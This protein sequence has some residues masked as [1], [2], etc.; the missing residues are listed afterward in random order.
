MEGADD[1]V[2]IRFGSKY[3]QIRDKIIKFPDSKRK[4]SKEVKNN[5]FYSQ[6]IYISKK[7][8]EGN[9]EVLVKVTFEKDNIILNIGKQKIDFVRDGS[10]RFVEIQNKNINSDISGA[11]YV[12][13]NLNTV[14]RHKLLLRDPSCLN[15]H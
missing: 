5:S 8:S 11:S 13:L 12:N 14:K 4:I 2:F 7:T 3:N 6:K 10:M 9:D 1:E 15:R